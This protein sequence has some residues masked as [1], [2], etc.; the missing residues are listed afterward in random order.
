MGVFN[1]LKLKKGQKSSGAPPSGQPGGFGSFPEMPPMPGEQDLYSELPNL[2]EAP[3]AGGLPEIE[4]PPPLKGPGEFESMPEMRPAQ[5]PEQ[6]MQLP[7]W[8]KMPAGLV[9]EFDATKIPELPEPKPTDVG[10]AQ[11]QQPDL[12]LGKQ[13]RPWLDIPAAPQEKRPDAG[14][15][16]PKL[17]SHNNSF[18]MRASDF[19]TIKEDLEEIARL[20]RKHHRLTEI[21]KEENSGFDRLNALAEDVQRRLMSVDRVLFE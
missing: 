2:P 16:I 11:S 21:R 12:R 13:T 18:F 6:P 4:L 17:V 19:A 9:P 15:F 1:F 3:E 7:E 10:L 5:E 8:P 14:E 20:Q